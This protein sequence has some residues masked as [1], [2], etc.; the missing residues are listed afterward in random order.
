MA[1]GFFIVYELE[2][3]MIPNYRKHWHVILSCQM[4]KVNLFRYTSFW[5]NEKCCVCSILSFILEIAPEP[6]TNEALT[7]YLNRIHQQSNK[8][9]PIKQVILDHKVIAGCGNIY[10]CE[11][12]FR[13]GVLPDKK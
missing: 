9:K 4:T 8:N 1:G 6:F 3:I 2:D 13:A 11:A 7:Y 12:L 10:A 5:R